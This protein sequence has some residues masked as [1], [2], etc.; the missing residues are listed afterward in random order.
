MF[1]FIF[2][3]ILFYFLFKLIF[4]FIIPIARTSSQLRK[5]IREQMDAYTRHTSNEQPATPTQPQQEATKPAKEDYIEFEEV[6]EN[7]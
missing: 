6:K 7:T 1:K 4:N 3:F 5:N 2:Y